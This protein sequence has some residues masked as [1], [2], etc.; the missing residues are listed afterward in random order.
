MRPVVKI[1]TLVA[2]FALAT[3]ASAQVLTGLGVGANLDDDGV[4]RLKAEI[5]TQIEVKIT[6]TTKS[7]TPPWLS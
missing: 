7:M 4:T 5:D 2:A 6:P 3:P 1:V